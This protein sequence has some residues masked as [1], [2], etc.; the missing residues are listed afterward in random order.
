MNYHNI[1]K[2]DMLNG[3]GVRTVLWVAGCTHGCFECHNQVTWDVN[4]GIP[5]DDAAYKELMAELDKDYVS[6]ITLSGGDPLHPM[7]VGEI[8]SLVEDIANVYPKKTIWLYTGFLFED[9]KTLPFIEK[10]DVIVD[11]KYEANQ[12][13]VN[14]PWKGSKNQRVIDVKATLA[15]HEIV[16]KA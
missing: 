9:I 15:Q 2:D 6:G 1:T 14:L 8:Q 3:E 16:L 11:G 12:R 10:I 13:S 5:F 4:G 7:N